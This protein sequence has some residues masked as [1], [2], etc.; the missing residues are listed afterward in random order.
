[1][2]STT[3]LA[4]DRRQTDV[5]LHRFIS[6]DRWRRIQDASACYYRSGEWV[7]ERL[8]GVDRLGRNLF[9]QAM[10]N[11]LDVG[12]GYSSNFEYLTNGSTIT[13]VD[14]RPAMLDMARAHA[15]VSRS[16]TCDVLRQAVL[17]ALSEG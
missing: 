1:M 14:V 5:H 9:A 4:I 13:G 11:V 2:S 16:Q 8:L 6:N 15:R 17:A 12:C 3:E 7:R 10:G